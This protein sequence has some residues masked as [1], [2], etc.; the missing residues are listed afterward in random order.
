MIKKTTTTFAKHRFSFK[1][2]P[3]PLLT[4]PHRRAPRHSRMLRYIR[5]ISPPKTKP[6]HSPGKKV[7]INFQ[8]AR[9]NKARRAATNPTKKKPSIP[10]ERRFTTRR[11]NKLSDELALPPRAGF[12]RSVIVTPLRLLPPPPRIPEIRPYSSLSM[13]H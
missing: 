13:A 7:R 9:I 11:Q 12:G 10:G 4:H 3:A 5:V 6:S 2:N 8:Q 1:Y